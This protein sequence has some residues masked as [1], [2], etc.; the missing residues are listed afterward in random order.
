M[1]GVATVAA[2]AQKTI[3][4]TPALKI[5][6]EFPLNIFRQ[7]IALRRQMRLEC[8]IVLRDKLIKKGALGAMAR[9]RRH[10]GTQAGVPASR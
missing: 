10:A 4:K 8:R 6:L 3:F 1:L 2:N 7:G 9:V 5:V